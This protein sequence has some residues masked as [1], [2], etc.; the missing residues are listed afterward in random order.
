MSPGELHAAATALARPDDPEARR[1]W[2]RAVVGLERG[3]LPVHPDGAPRAGPE[4]ALAWVV[5]AVELG[6]RARYEGI[7]LP[8]RFTGAVAAAAW[9]LRVRGA[10][11]D[12]AAAALHAD[13]VR[14]GWG[15]DRALGLEDEWT[16]WTFAEGGVVVL[17][18]RPRGV[19]ARIVVDAGRGGVPELVLDGVPVLA[20]VV[21]APSR[22]VSAR[23]DVPTGRGSCTARIAFAD[24]RTIEARQARLI[25][26]GATPW[27]FA[28]GWTV[29]PAAT[30]FV[31]RHPRC[32]DVRVTADA[33][34]T[35]FEWT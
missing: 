30:G 22:L 5:S 7:R 27:S 14:L 15:A 18:G 6:R 9:H 2:V 29:E 20:P 19:P 17:H 3:E 16:A 33:E 24:G 23:V 13:A 31:A 25:L 10:P 8:E 28:D 35:V 32:R 21:V 1:S 4:A 12:E 11:W 26:N 34:R